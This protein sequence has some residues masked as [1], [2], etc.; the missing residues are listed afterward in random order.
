MVFLSE[1]KLQK[2]ELVS[3]INTFGN[4]LPN[5]LCVDCTMSNSNRRGG[6]V[7]LWSSNVNLSIIG[8][9][10]RWIDCYVDCGNTHDSWRA[11]GIYG[12]SNHQQKPKTCDLISDLSI[13]NHHE[14]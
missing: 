14:N 4:R 10:E 6:L 11:T 8:F 7:M 5:H 13:S 1:T 9:N 3:K 2:T 12:Y